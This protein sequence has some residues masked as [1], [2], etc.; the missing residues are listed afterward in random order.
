MMG[1]MHNGLIGGMGGF[2]LIGALVG[3]LFLGGI[4]LAV[5]ALAVWLIRRSAS[6]QSGVK[7][8]SRIARELLEERYARGELTREE[9]L[10]MREDL[11]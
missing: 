3:L 10:S 8:G 2:G 9:F 4:V 6:G 5:A 1:G 11:G 7:D